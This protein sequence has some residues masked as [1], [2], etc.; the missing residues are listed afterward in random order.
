MVFI[1]Q[2]LSLISLHP[3][4]RGSGDE[5]LLGASVGALDVC[6]QSNARIGISQAE[7][8]RILEP[9]EEGELGGMSRER[10]EEDAVG[11]D[12]CPST[13]TAC[14]ESAILTH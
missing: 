6:D 14:Q 5:G 11:A 10:D 9:E 13:F 2:F 7:L 1:P 4:K 12:H 8:T 3:L